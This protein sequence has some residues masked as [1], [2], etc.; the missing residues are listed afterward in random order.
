MSKLS[1][2]KIIALY[3]VLKIF[4]SPKA[5]IATI[6]FSLIP[7][8]FIKVIIVKILYCHCAFIIKFSI[9]YFL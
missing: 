8:I 2:F 7:F 9:A 5:T 6:A 3:A 4:Y 1:F